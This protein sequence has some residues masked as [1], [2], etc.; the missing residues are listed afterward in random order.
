MKV[1]GQPLPS[2]TNVN[3]KISSCEGLLRKHEFVST[4]VVA[5]VRSRHA[6][7]F[8][9]STCNTTILECQLK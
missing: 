9:I 6:V 5:V 1:V 4:C 2:P 3:S 7:L 8:S